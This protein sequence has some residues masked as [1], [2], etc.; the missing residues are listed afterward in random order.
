MTSREQVGRALGK[1]EDRK[2]ERREYGSGFGPRISRERRR[3]GG[4]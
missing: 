1:G 4:S 3:K 2:E